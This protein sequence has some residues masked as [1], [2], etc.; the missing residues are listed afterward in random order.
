MRPQYHRPKPA[1]TGG[2]SSQPRVQHT[3]T[4]WYIDSRR[5]YTESGF[6]DA[7]EAVPS[8]SV[9]ACEIGALTVGVAHI[10]REGS[11]A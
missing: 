1:I 7:T 8:G 6:L 4:D 2:A 3:L 11:A 10:W 5:Q 9:R